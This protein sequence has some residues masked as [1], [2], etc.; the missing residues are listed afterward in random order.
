MGNHTTAHYECCS[1]VIGCER[2]FSIG[3]HVQPLDSAEIEKQRA[4]ATKQRQF[5]EQQ[6][7]LQMYGSQGSGRN[8]NADTLIESILG[9]TQPTHSLA[10]SA[11]TETADTQSTT[12]QAHQ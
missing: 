2:C 1:R 5:A 3:K 10:K 11:E 9:K 7:R 12:G 6:R 8:M 4:E